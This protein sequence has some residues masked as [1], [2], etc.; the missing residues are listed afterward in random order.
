MHDTVNLFEQLLDRL[1][2]QQ[3]SD[4]HLGAGRSAR[5]RVHGELL[6]MDTQPWTEG[7]LDALLQRLL[8]HT[9]AD[10]FYANGAADLGYSTRSGERF[11]VNA[12][13]TLGKAA[14]VARH[15]PA[16]FRSFTELRLPESIRQMAA[17]SDGLVLVTGIT[18]S[19]KSTTLA[20]I[21]NEINEHRSAHILS[22]EDPVEFVHSPKRALISHREL[23]TDVPDF[24]SAVKSAM[25]EDPDVILVGE[26]RDVDTMRAALTAAETGH[27]VLSTLHTADTSG[28]IERFVGAFPGEEQSVVRHR[29]SLVLRAVVAQQLLSLQSHAGRVAA[30]EVL[31]VTPAVANLIASGR[32]AQIYS[33]IESGRDVGMQTFDHSLAMLARDH[34]IAPEDGRRLARDTV[35]FERLMRMGRTAA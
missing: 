5:W 21:I 33:A 20:T 19:G 25:R 17:L 15:L 14:L 23:G 10:D 31:Q 30:V 8:G 34:L 12:F 28:A 9:Q 32:T 18:G 26:L 1:V 6:A 16:Q 13:R 35:G 29:L 7:M 2:E 11:R 4:L 22:I 3:A 27:L 24:A